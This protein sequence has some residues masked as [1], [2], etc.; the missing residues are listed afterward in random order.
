[1]VGGWR[2]VAAGGW[3]RLAV[4][5]WWRL[6]VDGGWWLA[7]DGPWGR[8]LRAVLNPKKKSRSQ[9]TNPALQ[10]LC[11]LTLRWKFLCWA[12]TTHHASSHATPHPP[13]P[14]TPSAVAWR[15]TWTF[16]TGKSSYMKSYNAKDCRIGMRPNV[17]TCEAK[18]ARAAGHR[19]PP[20][21]CT[22]P[23][24]LPHLCPCLAAAWPTVVP[25]RHSR[26]H[27]RKGGT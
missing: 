23:V 14:H 22:R 15:P 3:R 25:A 21:T 16:S 10:P 18:E 13:L 27:P 26:Q 24:A 9:R 6:A 7:V 12:A 17:S 1:M 19:R 5:G 11:C 8:S 20:G 4:G 2:L